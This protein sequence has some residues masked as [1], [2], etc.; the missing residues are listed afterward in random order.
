MATGQPEM[1]SLPPPG[2]LYDGEGWDEEQVAEHVRACVAVA[3]AERDAQIAAMKKAGDAMHDALRQIAAE[4]AASPQGE[5]VAWRRVYPDG[6]V[7]VFVGAL[8]MPGGGRPP[9]GWE[10]LYLSPAAGGDAAGQWMPIESAPRDERYLLLSSSAWVCEGYWDAD[11]NAFWE[12]N[13]HSTDAWGAPI[14]PT[15]WMP[16]PASPTTGAQHG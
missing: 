1:P 11:D 7:T 16:M 13:N 3:T 2:V 6:Q 4:R 9:E 5:P 14:Y 15:H 10:P 8:P 12:R